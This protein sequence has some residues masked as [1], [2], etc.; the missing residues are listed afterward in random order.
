VTP[1]TR[2]GWRWSVYRTRRICRSLL[3][4]SP[5]RTCTT[6]LESPRWQRTAPPGSAACAFFTTAIPPPTLRSFLSPIRTCVT[7]LETTSLTSAG[8]ISELNFFL[9][10]C[11]LL[12][13]CIRLTLCCLIFFSKQRDEQRDEQRCGSV[14]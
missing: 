2:S 7:P 10:T 12:N 14:R 9:F 11:I 13:K 5:P 6:A 3:F 1:T 8:T 4:R